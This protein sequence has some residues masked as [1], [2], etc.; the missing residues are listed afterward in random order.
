M[1]K[2]IAACALLLSLTLL[3][4]CGGGGAGKTMFEKASGLAPDAVL[5]TVEGREVPAWRYLYWL[6]AACDTVSEFYGENGQPVDW[7]APLDGGTL[8][9]YAKEQALADTVLYATVEQWAE[10]YGCA[11]TD[12]DRA[13]LDGAWAEKAAEHGGED[14]YL[15]DLA[16]QGLDR[17]QAMALAEDGRRYA[18]LY[19]LYRTA[20]SPL[21][22]TEEDLASFAAERGYLTVDRILLAVRDEAAKE[23]QRQRAEELFAQLNA[24]GDP[25][26][27]FSALAETYSDDP[28]RSRTV[29]PGAGALDPALEQAAMALAENQWSGILET[30]EGFSIL[31]RLPADRET[32]ASDY[33]DHLLQAAAGEAAVETTRA[34][35]GLRPGAFYKALT[36]AR[37]AAAGD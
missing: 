13:A 32:V 16:A 26:T 22:P 17:D 30:P 23:P 6:A 18:K 21:A 4:A 37:P 15:A 31:L 33:F 10:R 7:D 20:G 19:E 35:E 2:R 3:T 1:K 9:D 25:L 5:L 34:W 8:A 36:R 27:A 28:D 11:L 14:A 12:E 24:S 29:R